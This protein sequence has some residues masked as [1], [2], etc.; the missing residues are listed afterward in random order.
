VPPIVVAIWGFWQRSQALRASR[1]TSRCFLSGLLDE[2]LLE[3]TASTLK[4]EGCFTHE[5][6]TEGLDPDG[7]PCARIRSKV[8]LHA[9]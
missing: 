7:Q 3:R 1:A 9:R 8:A 5:F 6:E 4:A 2:E